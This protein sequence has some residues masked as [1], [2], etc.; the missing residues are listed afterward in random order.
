MS[1]AC[2]HE[3]HVRRAAA[4]DNWT[5]ALRE[6]VSQCEECTATAA[7][8]PFMYRFA[9]TSERQHRLPD[10][11]VVWLKAQLF[12]SSAIAQRVTRPLNVLQIAAYLVVAG[13][14]A[15]LLTW[16]WNALQQWMLSFTPQSVVGGIAGTQSAISL[17]FML[18]VAA[19]A[20]TTLMVALHTILAEE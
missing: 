3:A 13:G 17:P 8:A 15:G 5:D 1:E 14:W 20:S 19:L 10:A 4:E 11:S 16:K 12:R 7:V 6:H 2:R 18:V 9:R